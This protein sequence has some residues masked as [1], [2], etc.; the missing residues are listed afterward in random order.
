MND[1]YNYSDFAGMNLTASNEL[2]SYGSQLE[3]QK[4]STYSEESPAE[5]RIE[6]MLLSHSKYYI[7]C[8]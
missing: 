1:H 2:E 6:H 5:K 7:Y 4:L 8:E 3:L